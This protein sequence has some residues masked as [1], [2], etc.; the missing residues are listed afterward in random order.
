M[1]LVRTSN[2]S[3]TNSLRDVGV[4][5]RLLPSSSMCPDSECRGFTCF[6]LYIFFCFFFCLFFFFVFYTREQKRRGNDGA[7][8][9]NT[10]LSFVKDLVDAPSVR[11]EV[12]GNERNRE[13]NRSRLIYKVPKPECRRGHACEVYRT[14]RHLIIEKRDRRA[15]CSRATG[16]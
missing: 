4:Y 8:T 2:V 10:V 7:Y 13:Q 11:E 14:R 3:R 16:F 15:S 5:P 12:L 1:K 9:R 6:F